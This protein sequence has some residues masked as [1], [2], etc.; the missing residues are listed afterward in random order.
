[1]APLR[2]PGP[3][4]AQSRS[5]S[6]ARQPPPPQRNRKSAPRTPAAAP[7]A[8][9]GASPD[10]ED[11]EL[12]RPDGLFRGGLVLPPRHS[13]VLLGLSSLSLLAGLFAIARGHEA[14]APVPLSVFLTSVAYWARPDH[15]WRRALDIAVVLAALAFQAARALTSAGLGDARRALYF[16]VL[17]AG[18]AC[19]PLSVALH[20]RSVAA[21]GRAS[22]ASTA[23]HGLVHVLGNVSNVVLYSGPPF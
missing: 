6:R 9:D 17:G 4:G 11:E 12:C 13:R 3:R 10:D 5:T 8:A 1:M 18:M 19:A 22:W 16:A 14:L 7:R 20:R 15:S 23:L 21:G 2:A